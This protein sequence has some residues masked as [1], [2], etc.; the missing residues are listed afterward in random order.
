MT[1]IQPIRAWHITSGAGIEGLTLR[2]HDPV[3]AALAPGEVHVA[4]HAVSLSFRELLVARGRYVLPVK[5]DVVAVSDG[6]GEVVAVGP[7]VRRFRPGD[8]V[9][10]T[11]FPHWLD[12]PLTPESLPQLGGTLDG[13]LAEEVVLPERALVHAPAN[14][15]HAEAA[16][17]PCAA[18]TAWNALTGDGRGVHCGQTVVATGSGGVS[19]FA[20]Q[21]GRLLGLRVLATTGSPAKADRLR[22]LGADAVLDRRADWPAEVRRLTAGRGADRVIDTAGALPEALGCLTLDGHVALVGAVSGDWPALDPRLIFAK[23]ATVRAVAVGTRTQFEALN[24]FITA[25]DLHPPIARTFPFHQAREAYH[26]Y[27]SADPFGKVV[28]TVR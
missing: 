8:R 13:M 17:L 14:L 6:A 12:G 7:G 21:L 9:A 24:A 10:A 4:V 25:H 22:A 27:E 5:P 1:S 20:V 26:H 11:L 2:E 18:V 15:T 16:T 19:L 28:I 3:P 23:A